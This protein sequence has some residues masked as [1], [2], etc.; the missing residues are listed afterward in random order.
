MKIRKGYVS[1]SSSSSFVVLNLD[2]L[3]QEQ[4]DAIR[5]YDI[6]CYQYCREHNIPLEEVTEYPPNNQTCDN[7][8]WVTK[9]DNKEDDFGFINDPCGGFEIK[10]NYVDN[11]IDLF[12]VVENFDMGKWLKKLGVAYRTF[13]CYD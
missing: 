6:Y 1:N 13:G 2:K 5:C 12:T 3:S 10:I 9:T 7:K 8:T 11:C 4:I